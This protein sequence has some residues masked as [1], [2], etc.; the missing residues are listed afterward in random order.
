LSTDA[1]TFLAGH[2]GSKFDLWGSNT[3]GTGVFIDDPTTEATQFSY[4]AQFGAFSAAISL[5]DPESAGRR[6]AVGGTGQFGDGLY[7]GMRFPDLVANVRVD[8]GWGSAQLSGVLHDI[9]SATPGVDD[10][11]GWAVNGS[12]QVTIPGTS[13]GIYGT[14][15]Y[16]R[17]AVRYVTSYSDQN[18][19]ISD[20]DEDGIN[21]DKKSEAWVVRGGLSADLTPTLS[22]YLDGSYTSYD[23]QE[24]GAT[25]FNAWA[26]VGNLSWHPVDGLVIGG[27]VGYANFDYFGV[28]GVP[29]NDGSSDVW[30]VAVRVQRDF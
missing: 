21:P 19:N 2:A 6:A 26:V 5:E 8:Q 9:H 17:G 12:A 11:W 25:D 23:Q 3:F 4:T 29:N 30:S 22:A 1:G 18:G 16:G 13:F 20:A 24:T 7:G 27:E 28:N 10:D 14:G 15:T